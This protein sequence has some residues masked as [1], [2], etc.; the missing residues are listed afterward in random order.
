M[1]CTIATIGCKGKMTLKLINIAIN[2]TL[3]NGLLFL[4]YNRH[5]KDI[6]K[7]LKVILVVLE[8]D[9]AERLARLVRDLK[10]V[11]P[12]VLLKVEGHQG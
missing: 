5:F 6:L 1:N 7:K 9:R 3:F 11:A 2:K 10:G 12:T 8:Q 4:S